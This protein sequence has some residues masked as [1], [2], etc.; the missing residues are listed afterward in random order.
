MKNLVLLFIL[1]MFPFLNSCTVNDENLTLENYSLDS[2]KQ[3]EFQK[4]LLIDLKHA[5]PEDFDSSVK[6][7]KSKIEKI[8]GIFYLRTSFS[9]NFVSTTLLRISEE[10]G[11]SNFNQRF[12]T[13]SFEV[14]EVT[15]TSSLC[16]SGSGCIPKW[17]GDCSDCTTGSKD[18]T[19]SSSL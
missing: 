5:R 19:R 2:Q 6:I 9:N 15:C 18:C 11:D 17:N 3:R 13:A 7:T 1:V 10:N 4:F 16:T 8:D 14:A 12:V